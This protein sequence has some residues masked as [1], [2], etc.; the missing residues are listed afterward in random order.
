MVPHSAFVFHILWKR[1]RTWLSARLLDLY[2]ANS[3][4]L[5]M[6]FEHIQEQGW[7]HDLIALNNDLSLDLAAF[8]HGKGLFDLDT[9]LA[10]TGQS[11]TVLHALTRFLDARATD[12][13]QVH[14]DAPPTATPLTV[15]SVY[16]LLSFLNRAEL[17]EA[18]R[19]QL[20]RVCVSAYP[21][22]INYGSGYDAIIDDNGAD[23]NAMSAD[24]DA[25]M[26]ES[27][28][29]M[30]NGEMQVSEIID[31]LKRYKTSEDPAE[32]DLFACMVFGL[33]DEFNCFGEYPVDAL[34]TT[35]ALFGDIIK[36][37]LLPQIP[38]Q[39]GVAM[40]LE[41]VHDYD[42]EHGMFKFGLQA[43]LHFQIRLKEW[44]L[45]AKCLLAI[46]ALRGTEI[47]PIAERAAR[48]GDDS[49][50]HM[51]ADGIFEA[52]PTVRPF[53]CLSVDPPLRDPD[54]YEEP[55][56]TDQEI[57]QFILNNLS[58]TTLDSKA[59]ELSSKLRE[60]Y[61][62]WFAYYFVNTRVKPQL[63]YHGVYLELL[64][65]LNDKMLWAEVLR[66]TYASVVHMLNAQSTMSRPRTERLPL[67]IPFVC[68]VLAAAK[69][70]LVFK[71]PS[72][73]T[74]EIVQVLAELYHHFELKI[75]LKFEIEILCDALGVKV[76]SVEPSD[77]VRTQPA[78]E[79][80]DELPFDIGAENND[81]FSEFP[82]SRRAAPERYS[83]N[84]MLPGLQDL[85]ANLK[86]N[87]PLP[88]PNAALEARLQEVFSAADFATEPD[89]EKLRSS[90]HVSVRS[91]AGSLALVT[92]K[93][94]LRSG[95]TNNIR[96]MIERQMPEQQ[97]H[98]GIILMFVNDNI[99]DVCRVVESAAED[100]SV[101]EI[102]AQIEDIVQA[103][104]DGTYLEPA[105]PRWA[106]FVPDPFK[107]NANMGGLNR[108]QLAIYQDFARPARA[109]ALHLN[110]ISQDSSR[111][112]HD[113]VNEGYASMQTLTTPGE[114][115]HL[116][117]GSAAPLAHGQ[118][119]NG[120]TEGNA[121]GDRIQDLTVE[122]IRNAQMIAAQT[123]AADPS[124]DR[125]IQD[126]WTS[127]RMLL[128]GLPSSSREAFTKGP[129]ADLAG[130]IFSEPNPTV[131][132][133]LAEVLR[134]LCNFSDSAGQEAQS[135]YPRFEDERNLNPVASAVLIKY[136][137]V[138]VKR[139]DAIVA[140]ALLRRKPASLDFF[141]KLV[142]GLLLGHNTGNLR[143]DFWSSMLALAKW[144][145]DDLLIVHVNDIVQ[146]LGSSPSA[147]MNG[148]T[149]LDS[150]AQ[151][152]YI[153][154]EWM[155]LEQNGASK[156]STLA[157]LTQLL[158]SGIVSSN[159]RL[160]IF[161][162]SCVEL[163]L[164]A[165]S[166]YPLEIDMAQDGSNVAYTFVDSMSISS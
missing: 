57:V 58:D 2:R 139:I 103:R 137:L 84:Q 135:W 5:P 36:N 166:N 78:E 153:L 150:Q 157:F 88:G 73:W 13:Q 123:P 91:L 102:D 165:F 133:V 56:E 108:D 100:A 67:V 33:F 126:A 107:L 29:V 158:T 32:Q 154:E 162:F 34:A 10:N 130:F 26:Q 15:K 38:E 164:D 28:R 101:G 134:L 149:N 8:A 11:I 59:D 1:D 43:L 62:Q 147:R 129:I 20:Q 54:F 22:L 90:A 83:A 40:V 48:D 94:P 47:Y 39:V 125:S 81:G 161:L 45:F 98:D 93:D 9:W 109:M 25:K 14:R 70:S 132:N 79:L 87:Y 110:N 3:L 64:D 99:E 46:P 66:E 82:Y 96:L 151:T 85:V 63:N 76:A 19:I 50:R 145:G 121:V 117:R 65:R 160:A 138:D 37:N 155:R 131:S 120:F 61:Q 97:V 74:M 122:I 114:G 53:S 49:K 106:S 152:G 17:P 68:K 92:C 124:Q 75:Q 148:S 141:G 41:A 31:M 128:Q 156:S 116:P 95:M 104:K 60:P 86:H 115:S 55:S 44:T 127:I 111:H 136:N 27:F 7:L 163:S 30:Y 16:S 23:G 21:R 112:A 69:D 140:F 119:M 4:N 6:M 72:A 89:A 77:A 144:P 18:D 118:R 24:A 80:E 71:P 12:E 159:E 52:E 42:A 113:I 105:V 35:A 142:D 51:I 143:A 146:K